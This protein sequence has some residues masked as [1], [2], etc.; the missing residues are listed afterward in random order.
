MTQ[1]PEL[2]PASQEAAG[3]AI[4]SD[5]LESMGIRVTPD[6]TPSP[7]VETEP[8]PLV[9]V[10]EE[11]IPAEPVPEAQ[12]VSQESVEEWVARVRDN[13][14]SISAVPG[15]LRVEVT[16]K[17]LQAERAEHEKF[18]AEQKDITLRATRLAIDRGIQQGR[19]E[20]IAQQQYAQVDAL[21]NG[22]PA[23]FTRW[24][25]ENPQ[26]ARWYYETRAQGGLQAIAE[27]EPVT[28]GIVTTAQ[29]LL[30]T[31]QAYP[32]FHAAAVQRAEKEQLPQ[33]A[34]G[35][36]RLAII[37]SDELA[38]ARTGPSAPTAPPISSPALKDVPRP[39]GVSSSGNPPTP[40][41]PKLPNDVAALLDMGVR[42]SM[43][44]VRKEGERT[45][46]E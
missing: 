45:Q 8:A 4:A 7:D 29:T 46:Q 41:A 10:A 11:D 42:D 32:A 5:L 27:A 9:Q 3:A 36:Q 24:A 2:R 22:D 12:P 40:A 18:A 13:P 17:L 26:M 23:S 43:K 25:G 19:Q 31:L 33:T 21:A 1:A 30:A 35:L 14:R 20:V 6:A 34:E 16:E 37:V 15:L 38:N 39:S 44:R 28:R